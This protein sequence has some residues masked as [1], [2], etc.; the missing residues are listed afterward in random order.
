PDD[1]FVTKAAREYALNKV[2]ESFKR[3]IE[4][5]KGDKAAM[6]KE[7]RQFKTQLDKFKTESNTNV[8]KK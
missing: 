8:E 3:S 5:H 4:E 1:D 7:C 2:R 6:A